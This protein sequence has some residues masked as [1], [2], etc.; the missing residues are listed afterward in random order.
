MFYGNFSS[1]WHE[2]YCCKLKELL[3]KRD[4]DYGKA[5]YKS[6]CKIGKGRFPTEKDDPQD[7]AQC[8]GKANI[9]CDVFAER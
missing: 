6:K 9:I 8:A 4:S 5:K 3:S 1:E 2:C 7:I